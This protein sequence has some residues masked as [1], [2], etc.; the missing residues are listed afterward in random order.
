MVRFKAPLRAIV[1]EPGDFFRLSWTRNMGSGD[2]YTDGLFFA[3]E[4]AYDPE[5]ACVMITAVYRGDVETDRPFILDDSDLL[6]R[7]AVTS[8]RDLT[9]TDSSG[10]IPV[11]GGDLV[12]DGVVAGD[13]LILLDD[14]QDETTFSR[15]RALKIT[16][17]ATAQL[18]VADADLDFDAPGGVAVAKWEIRRS[19]LTAPT[20]STP[21]YPDGS[22]LYGRLSNTATPPMYSGNGTAGFDEAHLLLE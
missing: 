18:T 14:T 17:V 9:V 12:A 21:N 5:R 22:G 2:P 16:A 7:V 8:G 13:H 10:T 6:V 15:Y 20:T 3:D 11:S 4:V 19:H 1:L